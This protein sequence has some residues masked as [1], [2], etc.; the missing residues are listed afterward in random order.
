LRTCIRLAHPKTLWYGEDIQRSPELLDP[1]KQLNPQIWISSL[2]YRVD[3]Q[4]PQS[5]IRALISESLA[6]NGMGLTSTH[7]KHNTIE[8]KI[9]RLL[10]GT[11]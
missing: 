5:L 7:T 8:L 10:N 6:G 4:L 1:N 11:I 2:P 3:Y 9:F